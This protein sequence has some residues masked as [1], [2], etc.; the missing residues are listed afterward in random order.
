MRDWAAKTS[1]RLNKGVEAVVALLMALL[2]LDVWLGVVDR[3]FFHWQLPWPEIIARYLMIWA[4]MLAVS[5]GIARRDHIG[6][7]AAIM[8]VPQGL[9]RGVLIAIDLFIL[10]LFLYVFWYGLGFAESG[11]K[12]QAMIFGISL[13]PFYAAIPTA[14]ALAVIQTVL[15]MIRDTGTHLDNPPFQEASA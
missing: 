6:L 11:A 14:A 4:A 3:Y 10:A 12:R 7:T 2:V 13:Q 5:S 1:A 8:Q 15:V 9:R